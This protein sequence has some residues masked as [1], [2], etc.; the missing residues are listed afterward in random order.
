MIRTS[1]ALLFLA[2]C[3]GSATPIAP[4]VAGPGG[5]S[6]TARI[7]DSWCGGVRPRVEDEARLQAGRPIT[8]PLLVYAGTRFTG[9]TSMK[10]I[11]PRADGTFTVALPPGTY[12]VVTSEHAALDAPIEA[13]A[14][15]ACMHALREAC[16]ASWIVDAQGARTIGGEP[17]GVVVRP[18][19]S[20]SRP[21]FPPGPPPP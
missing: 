10:S 9:G 2:A 20:Y 13:G 16:D 17:L 18:G 14:D 6:G 12:C 7:Y 5:V 19:C 4:G 8:T 11:A 21:C 1:L 15:A 3:G